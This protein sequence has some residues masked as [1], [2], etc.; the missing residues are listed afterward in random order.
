[1]L[2]TESRRPGIGRTVASF[3]GFKQVDEADA[4]RRGLVA[5]P[6]RGEEEVC[7][8]AVPGLRDDDVGRAGRPNASTA[9]A[10]DARSV[11]ERLAGA[12]LDDVRLRHDVPP[13]DC[14]PR[15]LGWDG[16]WRSPPV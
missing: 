4:P 14:A 15:M 16:C 3:L 9:A 7:P 12:I 2:E 6:G 1:L 13:A 11:V 5:E 8:P 10:D